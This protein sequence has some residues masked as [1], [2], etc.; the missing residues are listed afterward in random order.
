MERAAESPR[1][2]GKRASDT[3][4]ERQRCPAAASALADSAAPIAQIQPVMNSQAL[5][6]CASAGSAIAQAAPAASWRRL[7][8]RASCGDPERDPARQAE[9]ERRHSLRAPP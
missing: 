7:A 3:G 6:A 4:A 5:I 8:T 2:H 9:E 1:S